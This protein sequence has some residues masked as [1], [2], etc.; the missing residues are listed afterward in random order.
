MSS[1]EH[2]L[3]VLGSLAE[4]GANSNKT[5]RKSVEFIST[6]KCDIDIYP[7]EILSLL[8]A[9][10]IQ[11]QWRLVEILV[12]FYKLYKGEEMTFQ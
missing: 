11:L 1:E 6:V 5:L 10:F 12:G 4:Y 7:R 3:S 2:G 9:S 8:I